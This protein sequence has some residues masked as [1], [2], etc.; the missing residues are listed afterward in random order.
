MADNNKN[1]SLNLLEIILRFIKE[2]Y[3]NILILLCSS[4]EIETKKILL[5]H[6][7]E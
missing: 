2:H 4:L 7:R 5:T 6:L 3:F 1:N